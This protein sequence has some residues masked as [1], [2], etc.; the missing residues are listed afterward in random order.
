MKKQR[1]RQFLCIL[2]SLC[3]AVTCLVFPAAAD[4]DKHEWDFYHNCKNC[5]ISYGSTVHTYENGY[6]TICGI[7]EV[8]G[9]SG[10]TYT[11]SGVC[12][13][14]NYYNPSEDNR[15]LVTFDSQGGSAVPSQRVESYCCA[16][17]PSPAPTR[18][19]YDFVGWFEENSETAFDF[20]TSI[21]QDITLYA[22]WAAT[23]ITY[24]DADGSEAE[25]TDYTLVTSS[26]ENVT[27]SGTMIASGNATINGKV[28]LTGDTNLIL[29]DGATLT[30]SNTDNDGIVCVD[31]SETDYYSLNIFGQTKQSGKLTIEA[32]NMGIFIKDINVYGGDISATSVACGIRAA[33]ACNI[34]HG[35][36]NAVA[37]TERTDQWGIKAGSS[38]TI[39][40]GNVTVCGGN[41]DLYSGGT[42]NLGWTTSDDRIEFE[43]RGVD[44][45]EIIFDKAFT[46][47]DNGTLATADN[48]VWGN[49]TLTPAYAVT[50]VNG[51]TLSAVGVPATGTATVTKPEDPTKEGYVFAGWYLENAE[52]AFDFGTIIT[53]DITLYAHWT[54]TSTPLITGS[55]TE[56]EP[57]LIGSLDALNAF[58]SDTTTYPG[59]YIQLTGGIVLDSNFTINRDCVIDF[60]GYTVSTDSPLDISIARDEV[61]LTDNSENHDG[62]IVNGNG[63]ISAWCKLN[64]ENGTYSCRIYAENELNSVITITGGT[65]KSNVYSVEGTL[66]ISGGTFEGTVENFSN[67]HGPI[68]VTGGTFKNDPSEF[69]PNGYTAIASG[70]GDNKVY[71]VLET[72]FTYLQSLITNTANEGTLTLD[73]DYT[74]ETG[75]PGLVIPSGKTITIDLNGHTINRGL[76]TKTQ[77]GYVIK[78]NGNL[79]LTDRSDN[80]ETDEY[81]GTGW[82]TGGANSSSFN[83]SIFGGGV[84]VS[85]TF[86]M[87]GGEI[88]GN[89]AELGGGVFVG[90][91]TFTMTGGTISGNTADLGG[92]VYVDG[93]FSMTGGTISS[94]TAENEGGGVFVGCGTFT[95]T[96]GTISD[97]TASY[98]GGVYVAANS[99]FTMTGGEIS[100]NTAEDGGG[101]CVDGTFSMS[102]GTITGNTAGVGGG[103]YVDGTFYLKNGITVTDDVYGTV[104]HFGNVTITE[105]TGGTVTASEGTFIVGEDKYYIEGETVTLTVT[106]ASGYMAYGVYYN[107]TEIVPVAGVYSFDMLAEDVTVTADFEKTPAG[108]ADAPY[109]LRNAAE[110]EAFMTDTTTYPTPEGQTTTYVKLKGNIE[111]LTLVDEKFTVGRN[112]VIDFNGFAVT[113]EY[114][115]FVIPNGCDVT[116][117]DNSASHNGGVRISSGATMVYGTLN[118]TNGTYSLIWNSRGG[119]LSI[120][121]GEF[122]D[123]VEDE[124][125][126]SISGGTFKK[127][128]N[129]FTFSTNTTI[130]GG[131]F[132]GHLY[133]GSLDESRKYFYITGGT[134]K[135]VI[136]VFN[137][138]LNITGGTFYC[139]AWETENCWQFIPGDAFDVNTTG[140]G[141][142]K[143]YTVVPRD[144]CTVATFSV[145]LTAD[146]TAIESYGIATLTAPVDPVTGGTEA[147]VT[148]EAMPGYTFLGWYPVTSVAGDKVSAYGDR[149]TPNLAYTFTVTKKATELVAVYQ[150]NGNATV[151][152][153]DPRATTTPYTVEP[154]LGTAVTITAADTTNILR[155]ENES[156]KVLGTSGTLTFTAIGN[157]TVNAVYKA[158][159]GQSFVQFVSDYGQVLSGAQ[160]SST[161]EITFPTVPTKF[162]YNFDMWVFEGTTDEAKEAAIQAKIGTESIITIK[163][164]YTKDST[165]YKV[166]VNY[167]N[168]SVETIKDTFID[169]NVEKGSDYTLTAPVINDYKFN[170]WKDSKGTIIGY[171]ESFFVFMTSDVEVTACYVADTETVL[172]EPVITLGTPYKLLVDN[173]MKVSCAVTRSVPDG[174]TVVEQG[175]LYGRD[176]VLAESSF[177]YTDGTNGVNRIIGN[178]DRNGVV[179][180]NVKVANANVQVSFR[181]YMLLKNENTGNTAYCYTNLLTTSYGTLNS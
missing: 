86:T 143:L 163:P 2:L 110:F 9:T 174:Y 94:N 153:N 178:N 105:P 52:T 82:I 116:F 4:C 133:L 10:H 124:G 142:D 109:L 78:V 56:E 31:G 100:Y 49:V 135:D 158:A 156:G 60:N 65:F 169:T 37:G 76:S 118:V 70:T 113:G 102:G 32:G 19:G 149:L 39:S 12:D 25:T 131:T 24:I 15:P 134:F 18:D 21:T 91:G 172:P 30:I 29:C 136:G 93:T 13:R 181:G 14:C 45:E 96:G 85:G 64:I 140:E 107:G 99:T 26:G 81:D 41:N 42:F 137:V 36:V 125:T 166:T 112:C 53:S 161:D 177:V 170:C 35:K 83:G 95:M 50:F 88:S 144:D 148:A 38:I 121:G 115:D 90:G 46:I 159:S 127:E 68:T 87:N 92:G 111:G 168:A 44:A 59:T 16:Y 154:Q 164:S 62:G 152:V 155:W 58:I 89:T 167:V 7:N 101:V 23:S 180:L 157:T 74:A 176:V 47:D 54:A 98:G 141:F 179:S 11:S 103:V 150:P 122:N 67:C 5:G 146:G 119:T 132:E 71:T 138:T 128:V 147:T 171:K 80:S 175:M 72:N 106:P 162:G 48:I 61:T 75:E 40:G 84:Y 160:Y 3:L 34:V 114:F 28:T 66:C 139:Q 145:G 51:E 43:Y 126:F 79:T 104:K 123:I 55:G 6:C 8:C 151:T 73:R 120:S 27:W 129:F 63:N 33:N 117:N 77:D 1:Q 97:N 165:K 108:T 173:V 130:S 57:Y 69:V 22:Y 17:E 20:S